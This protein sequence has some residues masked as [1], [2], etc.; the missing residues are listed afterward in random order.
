MTPGHE[1]VP[2]H[3]AR[4]EEVPATGDARRNAERVVE[5]LRHQVGARLRDVVRVHR[6]QRH[7]L[8][9]RERGLLA[10]GLVAAGDDD[11]RHLRR[12]PDRLEQRPRAPHVAVERG[13]RV[14]VGHADLRLRGQVQDGGD[15]VLAEQALEQLLIA[16]V[17]AH[18]GHVADPRRRTGRRDVV[19]DERDHVGAQVDQLLGELGSQ[20]P[21]RAGD[22]HRPV[23]PEVGVGLCRPLGSRSGSA[24]PLLP[25]LPGR[26]ARCSRVRSAAPAR[27]ACPWAGRNRRARRPSARR[28]WPSS[29]A[30]RARA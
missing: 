30:A 13:H 21:G 16:D 6:E 23:A 26:R 12:A 17:A 14:A 11:A 7:V 9:I 2:V 24:T 25:H 8:V 5:A 19:A 29:S 10:V 3:V 15:F 20:E 22:G 18:G 4:P 1:A 27:A 28:P